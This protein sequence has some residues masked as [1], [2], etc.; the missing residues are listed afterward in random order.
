[1]MTIGELIEAL[2]D[3]RDS[4]EQGSEMPVRIAYQ[5]NYPIAATVAGVA[6][7]SDFDSGPAVAWIAT[8]SMPYDEN[9]YA[10]DWAWDSAYADN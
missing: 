10:N 9:P 8:G 7:S 1:M 2:E 6:D 3:L 4:N 5:R